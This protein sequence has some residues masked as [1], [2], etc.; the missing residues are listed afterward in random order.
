MLSHSESL[1]AVFMTATHVV[2]NE[3]DEKTQFENEE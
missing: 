3:F 2:V 1:I